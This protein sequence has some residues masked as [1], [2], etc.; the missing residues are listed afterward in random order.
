MDA[1]VKRMRSQACTMLAAT[2]ALVACSSTRYAPPHVTFAPPR[3]GVFQDPVQVVASTDDDLLPTISSGRGLIA[4]AAKQNGNLDIMVRPLSGGSAMRLTDNSTDD[5]DPAF[6]P[7][8]A[9]IAWV[10]QA[11]DVKG[12]IWIMQADGRDKRRLTGR[13]TADQA[14]AWSPDGTTLYFSSR[15]PGSS[16]RRID[17]VTVATGARFHVVDAGW[18]PQVSPDGQVLFY[19][20]LDAQN[21][22]RIMARSLRDGHEAPL[23]DGAYIEATPHVAATAHGTTVIF[24][25]FVDDSTGNGVIDVDDIPSLWATDFKPEYLDGTAPAPARPLT[26]GEGGE[27]FASVV[28]DTTQD[29]IVYTAAGRGALEI[30]ALPLDG[31][32]KSSSAPEAILEAARGTDDPALRRLALRYLVAQSPT[33]AGI[34]RYELARELA[35]R[36]EWAEAQAALELVIKDAGDTELATVARLEKVRL[37]MLQGL[38]GKLLTRTAAQRTAVQT[39]LQDVNALA[40]GAPA[41]RW[42]QSR[43]QSLRGEALFALQERQKAVALFEDLAVQPEVNGED[44]ARVLDRL[45]EAYDALGDLDAV[46][47]VSAAT[48]RTFGTQRYYARRAADRWVNTA[49]TAVGV[50]RLAAL[51]NIA[52]TQ[53][54]LPTVAARAEAALAQT[55]IASGNP[56]VAW[57]AWQHIADAHATERDILQQALLALGHSG[58]NG[59]DSSVALAA[60]ERLLVE[61]PEVPALRV[62]ARR[63]I[64]TLALAQAREQERRGDWQTARAL[65]ARLLVSNNA[66]VLAHRRYIALSAQLGELKTVTQAY[67]DAAQRMPHDKFARYGYGYALSFATPLAADDARD[68]MAAALEIDP[69]FAAAHLTLGWLREQQENAEPGHGRLEA[70][71]ESYETARTFADPTV[72]QE[73]WA[74]ATLN[75]GNA[76]FA[77]AKFDDAFAAYLARELSP[78]PF[79]TP[80]TQL[81]FRQ[82]FARTALREGVL[83]VALDMA[84]MGYAQ[85][86][87][88]PDK[89]RLA[90]FAALLAALCTQVDRG[91]EAIALYDEAIAHYMPRRD[92]QHIVP[93]LR[94]K[95]LAQR[96]LGDDDAALQT[97]AEILTLLQNGAEL[98][99]PPHGLLRTEI[100]ANPQNVSGAVYGFDTAQET[101][102]A[103]AYTARILLGHA[104]LTR[105]TH[106]AER[107]LDAVRHAV[108]DRVQGPRLQWELLYALHESA[109]LAAQSAD[110]AQALALWAE[111]LP[112]LT[113]QQAWEETAT[114]AEAL[115]Q[116]WLAHPALRQAPLRAALQQVVDQAI[117]ATADDAADVATRLQ[118]WVALDS[119]QAWWTAGP[120]PLAL[121]DNAVAAM[122]ARLDATLA[123]AGKTMQ[124]AQKAADPALQAHV[125]ALLHQA[126]SPAAPAPAVPDPNNWRALFDRA[127]WDHTSDSVFS[128]TWLQQAM[129]AF[130]RASDPAWAPERPTFIAAATT[131]LLHDNQV[132]TA[133]TWLERERLL[134]LQPPPRR[135]AAAVSPGPALAQAL[136]GVPATLEA[137]RTALGHDAALVQVFAP[138]PDAWHWFVIDAQQ[139][140][141]IATAA[142]PMVLPDEVMHALGSTPPATLYVD[143]GELL[144]T[145]AWVWHLTDGTQLGEHAAV[146]EVLSASYLLAAYE[147]RN[148]ARGPTLDIGATTPTTAHGETLC[149]QAADLA[150]LRAQATARTLVTWQLPA[151]PFVPAYAPA[152]MSQLVFGHATDANRLD[153]DTLAS[154]RLDDSVILV[155]QSAPWPTRAL[156]AL[157]QTM[158]LM[159]VPTW[160]LTDATPASDAVRR[161]LA[162]ALPTQQP[163]G[164]IRQ[165]AQTRALPQSARI[166]GYR[167]MDA[168]ARVLFAMYEFLRL[169]KT[170]SAA[171]KSARITQDNATWE[172]ARDAFG[173][174]LDNL[175]LLQQPAS[176]E[177]L[178]RSTDKTAQRLPALLDKLTLDNQGNLAQVYIALKQVDAAVALQSDIL[179]KSRISHDVALELSTLRTLGR[180]LSVGTRYAASADYFTQCILRAVELRDVA[181]QAE[182]TAQLA[183]ARQAQFDYA[184]AENAYLQAIALYDALKS[185]TAIATRRFLGFLYES[186]LNNYDKAAEQFEQARAAAHTLN[187]NALEP[188]LLLDIARVNRQRGDYD[189]AL[190]WVNQAANLLA[191]APPAD[192]AEA[193]LESAKI[194]W[195][196]GHYRLALSQQQKA[197]SWAR[198]AG[199]QFQEIQAR[200]LAGLIALNQGA[201]AQAESHIT[202]ALN[203]SRLTGR[204]SEE[205]AQLNNLGIVLREANRLDDAVDKFY[206]AQVIDEEHGSIEGKAYDLRNLAVAMARQGRTREALVQVGHALA[207][208]QQIGNRYNELQCLFAQGEMREQAADP[209]ALATLQQAAQTARQITVPEVEWR[210]WYGVARLTKSHD[211][212]QAGVAFATAMDVVERLGHG[213]Q[214]AT[215]GKSRNDL[216]ADAMALSI[217]HDDLPGAFAI[218]ERAR[219]R[220]TRDVFAAKDVTFADVRIKS[221]LDTESTQRE[222]LLAARRGVE[223]Q[224]P[225]AD[226]ALH[227]AQ[228]AHVNAQALLQR[229]FP[230]IARLLTADPVTLDQ[231]QSRLPPRTAV[232]AYFFGSQAGVAL[233]IDAQHAQA[234]PLATNATELTI[235][236]QALRRAMDAFAPVDVELTEFSRVLLQPLWESIKDSETLIVVP[237]ES[238]YQVP[239]AALPINGAP[240]LQHMPVAWAMSGS[241]LA[242]QLASLP[243]LR[244]RRIVAMA[245]NLDLP[246]ATL[247][248]QAIVPT[249]DSAAHSVADL[250]TAMAQAD[251]LDLAV[252]G[253]HDSTDPLAD[254]LLLGT[255]SPLSDRLEARAIFGYERVPNL[256]SLSACDSTGG[257]WVTLAQAFLGAGSKTVIATQGRVSDFA[258]AVVMKRFYRLLGQPHSALE[259]PLQLQPQ[260]QSLPQSPSLPQSQSQSLPQQNALR[261]LR[262]A[263]LWARDAY[264]HPAHWAHFVLIGDFR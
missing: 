79:E 183:A 189:Q 118:R 39:T 168:D 25:Q 253:I 190:A 16:A 139:L 153:L 194:Y 214:E 223:R 90:S 159:G 213:P 109:R 258:T 11:E 202:E 201:L 169:F 65:Y 58:T 111:A 6:A 140:T 142:A 224:M 250:A 21:R 164:I 156:R 80:L 85:S 73:I 8:G 226:N 154:I 24:A 108:A 68:E 116:V 105:A 204:R 259:H 29:Y 233:V 261:A 81:L 119:L 208:S 236:Q 155:R 247:E 203:L 192:R 146:S 27:I 123:P 106:F 44:G 237:H 124:A 182:C 121:D 242:D 64:T 103:Q 161:S 132:Q 219:S 2:F 209:N 42:V 173:R 17:A 191:D 172:I 218:A 9:T 199:N 228:T 32:I 255:D 184:G 62:E 19:V 144:E 220:A 170:G 26:A 206:A 57:A 60:Y 122:L 217:A 59:H 34:A 143:A 20:R 120:A 225:D 117:T 187:K 95:A 246:F 222:A 75:K 84:R 69:R 101:A 234:I 198:D 36:G 13:E 40:A 211:P 174:V 94:G 28:R 251:A 248:A 76:L 113:A 7:D 48:V 229:S 262:E 205:A 193:A 249:S 221:L 102:I 49:Q 12:D 33:L 125:C 54:D 215:P 231:L 53:H 181:T 150:T 137:L 74:A 178:H 239:F 238:L 82:A 232:V 1:P 197:L 163:S 3:H 110:N 63:G 257:P 100:A 175:A 46:A 51:E 185:E 66:L 50:P 145:P 149:E 47:R 38:D 240:L 70:A 151:R 171:F 263:A 157:S 86:Q 77:L 133:W 97:F 256:V 45:G 180:T 244:P 210:A 227:A 186:A 23:T 89:P 127:W 71:A 88:L 128:A 87:A 18:D 147:T 177:R 93:L 152:G 130:N 162:D 167:G 104:D 98:P 252:H 56:N 55:Q 30:Y 158:L 254:A 10:S 230:K 41:A 160:V 91:A 138:T 115:Q 52:R 131:L 112:I 141:H 176:R 114:V 92:W 135:R 196:R 212:N 31:E 96:S 188:H 5:S 67:H 15:T 134:T 78:A 166:M 207:L 126:P 243:M 195:Y 83:D 61:F 37:H 148:A 241:A 129:E 165:L 14:P 260:S 107:R 35:E 22:P 216:Y 136:A 4:Y 99:A 43:A 245:P 179:T 264:V 200:S 72:D 235:R